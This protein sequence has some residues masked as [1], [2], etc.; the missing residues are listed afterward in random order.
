MVDWVE[1]LKV[2][3][4]GFG[5]V[6]LVLLILMLSVMGV[7]AIVR[8]TAKVAGKSAEPAKKE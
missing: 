5:G 2:A 4:I 8:R 7:S 6:I 1:A 3:A